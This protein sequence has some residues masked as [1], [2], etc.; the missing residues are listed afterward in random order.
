MKISSQS[1]LSNPPSAPPPSVPNIAVLKFEACLCAYVT[2]LVAC[3]PG[4]CVM[5]KEA[6]RNHVIILCV[7]KDKDPAKAF[8]SAGNAAHIHR[9][10]HFPWTVCCYICH[11]FH[12]FFC[13]KLCHLFELLG[14]AILLRSI[15]LRR[16]PNTEWLSTKQPSRLFFCGP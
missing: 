12:L 8:G 6:L 1:A 3:V 7:L 10:I 11:L 4:T 14:F 2:S 5:G 16:I 9:C 15:I 13:H